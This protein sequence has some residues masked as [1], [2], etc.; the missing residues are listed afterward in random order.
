[1][2]QVIQMIATAFDEG[3]TIE[4][5]HDVL[6]SKGYTEDDCFLL[7]KAGKYL[8]ECRFNLEIEKLNRKPP[9][10]RR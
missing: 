4:K 7:I 6:V 1:M 5:I 9:F 10:G 2:D 8:S 3:N